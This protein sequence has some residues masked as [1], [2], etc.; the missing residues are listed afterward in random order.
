M[1][2]TVRH[3]YEFRNVQLVPNVQYNFLHVLES[4]GTYCLLNPGI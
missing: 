1:F 4:A 3:Y 2:W